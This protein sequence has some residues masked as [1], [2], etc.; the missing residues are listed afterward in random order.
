MSE[1]IYTFEEWDAGKVP[2]TPENEVFRP[3]YAEPELGYLPGG[4]IGMT[5]RLLYYE[6]ETSGVRLGEWFAEVLEPV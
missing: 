1:K 4:H 3:V 5:R 2:P 6:G